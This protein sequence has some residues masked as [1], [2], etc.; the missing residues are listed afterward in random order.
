M[1]RRPFMMY[2]DN[3]A[4]AKGWI[5]AI[6][7][8]IQTPKNDKFVPPPDKGNDK[9]L[10]TPKPAAETPKPRAGNDPRARL[11][12]AKS[13]I[14][15]LRDEE[16]KVLEFWKIWSDS[17]PPKE[18]L[19]AG[20]AIEFFVSMSA[21]MQKITWR[22]NGPQHMF[23]QKMV[24]FF[25]NVGAPDTEIDLLNEVG[26]SINP[27]KIGSWIDMSAKGGMDG[28]WYFPV[29]MNLKLAVEAA[30]AGDAVKKFVEWADKHGIQNVYAVGRDMGAA[31]PRQTEIRLKLPG[32]NLEEQY[33]VAVDAYSAFGFPPLPDDAMK[34]LR[35]TKLTVS[36]ENSLCLSVITSSEGFVRLGL[37]IPKPA[38]ES[39]KELCLFVGGNHEEL[40]KFQGSFA[41]QGPVFVEFQYLMKGYGYEVYKEGFDVMFHYFV[42]AE[43]LPD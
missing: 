18:E 8:A 15:F 2:P 16:S 34:I 29:E 42:G 20:L 13:A 1:S 10:S 21:D 7:R 37:I 33:A 19:T 14:S 17:I 32:N 43:E 6:G 23:I 41:T 9:E 39:V 4:D 5:D 26:G 38:I 3:P 25:W 30:D 24:D 35:N 11:S 36:P 12:M 27:M 28:G 40:A 22:T 31:P